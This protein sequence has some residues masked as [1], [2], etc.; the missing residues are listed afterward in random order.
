MYHF[1]FGA[2]PPD[3]MILSGIGRISWTIIHTQVT[4]PISNHKESGSYQVHAYAMKG[5]EAQ[6]LGNNSLRSMAF[7][8]R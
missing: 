1:R 7:Q 2:M 6:F 8:E 3:R 5:S 4:I